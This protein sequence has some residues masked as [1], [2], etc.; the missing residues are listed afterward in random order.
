MR[1][2]ANKKFLELSEFSG[3][4]KKKKHRMCLC[5]CVEG[6]GVNFPGGGDENKPHCGQVEDSL[7]KMT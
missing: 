1:K 3:E 6:G 4:V 2:I 5:V 7:F